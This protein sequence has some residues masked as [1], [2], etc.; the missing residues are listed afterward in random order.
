MLLSRLLA[1]F[2]KNFVWDLHAKGTLFFK[3]NG[4]V[5][6]FID[7]L[8]DGKCLYHC[9]AGD[10]VGKAPN[11]KALRYA[12]AQWLDI[13]HEHY[14]YTRNIL[15]KWK[16]QETRGEIAVMTD[17]SVDAFTADFKAKLLLQSVGPDHY[18]DVDDCILYSFLSGVPV[19]VVLDTKSDGLEVVADTEKIMNDLYTDV[20]EQRLSRLPRI[21]ADGPRHFVFNHCAGRPTESYNERANHYGMLIPAEDN[22]YEDSPI[23]I[24]GGKWE[25]PGEGLVVDPRLYY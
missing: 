16:F 18:G 23:Y 17:E 11:V 12:L 20:H 25:I 19:S 13:E 22:S 8:G 4:G 5:Y 21:A 2:T 14:Q 15:R 24:G 9:L 10:G 1:V 7:V 3:V 6:R